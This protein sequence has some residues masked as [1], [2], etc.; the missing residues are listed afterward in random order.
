MKTLFF[1]VGIISAPF[2]IVALT[3][4]IVKLIKHAPKWLIYQGWKIRKFYGSPPDYPAGKLYT[5]GKYWE[6]SL[7][8]KVYFSYEDALY[9]RNAQ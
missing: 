8:P 3:W 7:Q 6:E 9:D 1:W 4:G 5:N 2:W